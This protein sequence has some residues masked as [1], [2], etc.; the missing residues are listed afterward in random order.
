MKNSPK[1]KMNLRNKGWKS[2]RRF[3]TCFFILFLV[4]PLIQAQEVS[5][6][7]SSKDKM[8]QTESVKWATDHLRG[9]L[10]NKGVDCQVR[11][12]IKKVP[13]SDICVIIAGKDDKISK[14]VLKKQGVAVADMPE[15][16]V[17]V[18]GEWSG[19]PVVLACGSDARGLIY[20]VVELADRISCGIP[21]TEA[22]RVTE[23]I[24]EEP[25]SRVRGIYR[26]FTNEKSDKPWYNDRE[27]WTHY[28]TELATQRI[29]RFSLAL[30]MAYNSHR[31]VVD[32]YF[33]FPYPFFV[34]V[35]GY[36]V[37][38][39]GLPDEERDSNLEMLKFI[40]EE[41]AKRGMEFQLALWSHGYEFPENVNYPI[42]G[43]TPDNHAAYC[44]DAL[45]IILRTCPSITGTTFRVHGESGIPQGTKGF[46][47]VLFQAHERIGR[48]VWIDMHGKNLTQDQLTWALNTG[49]PVSA[50]PK[51]VGEHMGLPYHTADIRQREKGNIDAYREPA[52]G[53]DLNNRSYTRQGYGD[54]LPEDREWHV[55]H[56]IWPGTNRLLL[57]GD[58]AFY[59]GYGR[60][61]SFCSSLGTD[62][63]DPLTFKG[64]KGSDY[65]GG[66]CG[67]ADLSL[68]P[69]WDYQ[70]YLY[71][72]R[73]WGRLQYNPETDPEV[74]MRYL[75]N[76][77]GEAALPL[78]QAMAFSTRVI[79]LMTTAHGAATNC[80]VYWPEI[81][82]NMPVVNEIES[83]A[84]RDNPKPYVFGN[85]EPHDP[86]LFA[87]MNDY[88]K[89]LLQG[90]ELPKY[91][92]LLV[93]QWFD[94]MAEKAGRNL[95]MAE[96]LVK[97]KNDPDFRRFYYD[98]QIQCGIARFFADKMRAAVLWHIF[99]SSG[100]PEALVEGILYYTKGRDAWAKMAE[101]VKSVYSD[102]LT[103][104]QGSYER[105][106]WID[107][108][109]A[110]DAD[111]ADMQAAL[112]ASL[113][114]GSQPVKVGKA[115]QAIET[116]RTKPVL[117]NIECTH[118]LEATFVPGE[119]I[120]VELELGSE[121]K[122]VTLY[123]RHVN[124]ALR[125]QSAPMTITGEK[126][127]AVIPAEY[128]QT[129]FPMSYYFVIDTGEKGKIIYPGL[130]ADLS[131]MPYYV[132]RHPL[133]Q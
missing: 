62:R 67:Y 22:L 78:Q 130:D 75:Q 48:P 68:E 94:E 123:Y 83:S 8:A 50:S 96:A 91:S 18:E 131:N 34:D 31:G 72:Y 105:G 54:F 82:N 120:P 47:E 13:A 112:A 101:E 58:P 56:R 1:T 23:A 124:Q 35:P 16:L 106:H 133:F 10:E 80:T 119:S 32:S 39:T 73:L 24:A 38:A 41:T 26:T 55:W 4:L 79:L 69:K 42:E 52:S 100:D 110:M 15:S 89:A 9:V 81:Y 14:A 45:E 43:L 57:S 59:S 84:F 29:N 90:E 98:I 85:V 93:A 44:R 77:F 53:V 37:R 109:P 95:V 5:L 88:A 33:F 17:L 46:W 107:R 70:K 74:W 121:A 102:D 76:E 92:P 61:A 21:Y 111:I 36:S 127:T 66:R 103:F 114:E 7:V 108:I 132:L 6:L 104:G 117:P 118:T 40:S 99:E 122:G 87:K 3:F 64:R 126:C 86:Q 30:G 115:R 113:K 51:Y 65:S 28:L 129:R 128:T 125:W 19:R 60:E 116:V 11:S 49:M 71:T 2:F 63:P 12:D 27:F 20:A 25:A 97:D